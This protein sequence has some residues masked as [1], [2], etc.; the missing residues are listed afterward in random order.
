MTRNF[1]VIPM[2]LV[3][4]DTNVIRVTKSI[5]C[6]STNVVIETKESKKQSRNAIQY[7][8]LQ[9]EQEG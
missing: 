4:E 6:P 1:Y 9:E 8:G 2:Y 5:E 3:G 7:R